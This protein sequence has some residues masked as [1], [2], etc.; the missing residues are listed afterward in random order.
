MRLFSVSVSKE[1]ELLKRLAAL[2]IREEDL[3]EK[4]VRAQGPGGQRLNKVSTCVFLRHRPTGISVKC[5]RERSRALNR[6]L[7]RQR[8]AGRI[9]AL[10]E[11]AVQEGRARAAKIRRQKKR[12]SR[13]SKQKILEAKHRTSEKK[14]LRRPVRPPQD[15]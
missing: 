4:F 15:Q 5:Q 9:E 14:V 7:A 6:Y 3:D 12:R 8:L 11:G 2:G 10:K 13:R 1:K